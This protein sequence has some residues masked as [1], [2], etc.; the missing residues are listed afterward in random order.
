MLDT[1]IDVL[2]KQKMAWSWAVIVGL[3]LVVVAHAPVLPIVA[4]SLLAVGVCVLR[5]WPRSA[6]SPR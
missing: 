2:K 1:L 3:L 4:G 5:A 6:G